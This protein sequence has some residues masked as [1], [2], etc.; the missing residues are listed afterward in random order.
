MRWGGKS[1]EAGK[2]KEKKKKKNIIIKINTKNFRFFWGKKLPRSICESG[3]FFFF[4]FRK[5]QPGGLCLGGQ[6]QLWKI[7]EKTDPRGGGW[8][9]GWVGGFRAEGPK[10]IFGLFFPIIRKSVMEQT[11]QKM[12]KVKN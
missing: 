3:C 9:P 5:V 10:K 8:V 6:A 11:H 4:F 1:A 7:L 12:R 2:K